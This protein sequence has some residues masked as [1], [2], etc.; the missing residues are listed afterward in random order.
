MYKVGQQ[1]HVC[2]IWISFYS[3]MYTNPTT[4]KFPYCT[5][6]LGSITQY[7]FPSNITCLISPLQ[8]SKL[9]V[10][11]PENRLT[12]TQA[13][14]HP[15]L[16]FQHVEFRIFSA[17]R[18]FKVHTFITTLTITCT[19]LYLDQLLCVNVPMILIGTR[20]H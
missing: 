2:I 6:H 4:L 9:L 12:A 14:S 17:K 10:T 11:N 20:I 15:F 18:K 7:Y 8:I 13:L 19:F 3:I 5:F 16:Q 1:L